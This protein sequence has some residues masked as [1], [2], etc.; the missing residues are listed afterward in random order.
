[1][2]LCLLHLEFSYSRVRTKLYVLTGV[3]SNTNPPAVT[4]FHVKNGKEGVLRC[5]LCCVLDLEFSYLSWTRHG[6]MKLELLLAVL[7]FSC[8]SLYVNRMESLCHFQFSHEDWTCFTFSELD[9]IFL[10]CPFFRMEN[11]TEGAF[12]ECFCG[13]CSISNS[14]NQSGRDM[15]EM[16][17]D[18]LLLCL[19][20]FLHG[21]HFFF[22]MDQIFQPFLFPIRRTEWNRVLCVTWTDFSAGS[23]FPYEERNRG[24][25]TE[26]FDL[27]FLHS[28]WTR[29]ARMKSG[30]LL[31]L[32]L[33]LFLPSFTFFLLNWT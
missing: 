29:H 8:T 32:C 25:I 27:E 12:T 1:M 21:L 23:I 4:I 14:R 20:L 28:S 31:L 11:G 3:T 16:N 13:V 5:T 22:E 6:R 10:P 9:R 7:L 33:F 2:L 30:L 15:E 17:L 26:Y 19:L 18:L 24:S